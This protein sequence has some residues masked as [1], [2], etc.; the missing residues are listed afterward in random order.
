MTARRLR[1]ERCGAEFSCDLDGNCWCAAEPVRLPVPA[2]ATQDC[3][4]P[5]CLRKAASVVSEK[6]ASPG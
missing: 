2:A 5:D 4:C 1:C 3:L 6:P